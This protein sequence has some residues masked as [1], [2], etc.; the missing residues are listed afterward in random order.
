MSAPNIIYNNVLPSYSINTPINQLV[1]TNSGGAVSP[2]LRISTVSGNSNNLD[3]PKDGAPNVATYMF[4]NSVSVNSDGTL[5]VVDGI[6]QTIRLINPSGISSTLAGKFE[7][8][9]GVVQTGYV[10]GQGSNARFNTPKA[11]AF[12]SVGNVIVLDTYNY[13]I[14]KVTPT[15][16]VTTLAGSGVVGQT[17]GVGNIAKF[18]FLT[19]LWIDKQDNIFVTDGYRVRKITPDGTVS[20]IAGNYFIDGNTNGNGVNA[21]FK[22]MRGI[23]SD[24]DG[25]LYV[26]DTDNRLIRRIDVNKNV[27][28]F[29][30]NIAATGIVFFQGMIYVSDFTSNQIKSVTKSGV[31]VKVYA[32]SGIPEFRD[33]F[34]TRT[35]KGGAFYAPEGL[36]ID[37]NRSIYIADRNS[38][39]IRKT[40]LANYCVVPELPEGLILNPITGVISGIPTKATV[41]NLY[42]VTAVNNEGSSSAI[43]YFKTI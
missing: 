6:S 11:V 1:P 26:S 35:S 32:G 36:A 25:N 37:S 21:T 17:D 41:S 18:K 7:S 40:D 29:V 19:S 22:T 5:V 10:D 4:P 43:L 9:G 24:T 14:R 31:T 13:R 28:T 42:T 34:D 27:I 23:V 8:V 20:T 38:M 12:D 30:P 3:Y 16:V 39:K 15:G 33:G 2:K